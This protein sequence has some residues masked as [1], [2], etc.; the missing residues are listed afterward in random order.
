M[1]NLVWERYPFLSE[2]QHG[3]SWLVLLGNLGRADATLDAYARALS[4]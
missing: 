3:R 1:A 2:N 4:N